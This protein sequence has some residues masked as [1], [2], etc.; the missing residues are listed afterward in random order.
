LSGS[1]RDLLAVGKRIARWLGGRKTFGRGFGR[2]QS[3][4][5]MGSDKPRVEQLAK[6]GIRQI[7]PQWGNRL[8]HS[9]LVHPV[10]RHAPANFADP[11]RLCHPVLSS[12]QTYW[13]ELVPPTNPV[14]RRILP[15]LPPNRVLVSAHFGDSAER[16]A[17]QRNTLSVHLFLPV[18]QHPTMAVRSSVSTR[19]ASRK[20]ISCES[21]F[22]AE[23]PPHAHWLN[24][25]P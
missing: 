8:S 17:S 18:H 10:V 14:P 22:I 2:R 1:P 4:T 13:S 21:A 12:R 3:A 23:R 9:D 20:T 19:K 5:E 16:I 15:T 25:L 6:Q 7:S 24:C 11:F